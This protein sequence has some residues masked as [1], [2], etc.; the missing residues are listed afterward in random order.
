MY[1]VIFGCNKMGGT[2]ISFRFGFFFAQIDSERLQQL[3]IIF[4]TF[5]F[6]CDERL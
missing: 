5:S 6:W 4:I 1:A 3:P 2:E